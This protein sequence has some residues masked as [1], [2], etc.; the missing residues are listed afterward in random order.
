MSMKK[1]TESAIEQYAI[2]LLEKQGYQYFYAPDIAPD[3]ETPERSSFEDVLLVERLKKAV[4]RITQNKA[5]TIDAK[6]DQGL[7]NNQ[8]STLEKLRDSLLPKLMSGEVRV[9]LEQQKAGT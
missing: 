5:K 9:K 4:G 7:N 1:I 6:D 3:S 2:D 8:I